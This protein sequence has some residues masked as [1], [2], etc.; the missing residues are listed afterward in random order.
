MTD[1]RPDVVIYHAN[2]ADGFGAA[3]A[4]WMRWGS[5]IRFVQ[6]KTVGTGVVAGLNMRF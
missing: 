6:V 1:Y 3:W 4:A 2:C 5:A